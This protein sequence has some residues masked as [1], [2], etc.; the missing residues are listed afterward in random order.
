MYFMKYSLQCNEIMHYILRYIV[1]Y[2]FSE[3]LCIVSL[4]S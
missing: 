3:Y 1:V 2:D 4:L